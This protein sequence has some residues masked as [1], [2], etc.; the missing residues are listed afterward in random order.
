MEKTSWTDAVKNERELHRAKEEK[1]VP[2][3]VK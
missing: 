1:K 2:N 3:S